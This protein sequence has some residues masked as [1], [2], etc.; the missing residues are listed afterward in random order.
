LAPKSD[1]RPFSWRRPANGYSLSRIP[2]NGDGVTLAISGEIDIAN[3]Q[4]F[5]DEMH[6]L[7][8]GAGQVTLDLQDCRFI[9]STGIRALV[10]VA[11]EQQA[12]G[13]NLTLSGVTG[14]PHRV[15]GLTGLLDSGLFAKDGESSTH[16]SREAAFLGEG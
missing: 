15:L 6:S 7:V 11:R 13:R 4:S 1:S 16:K 2:R 12:Q 9:D 10:L 3:A 14:E 5:T 8:E